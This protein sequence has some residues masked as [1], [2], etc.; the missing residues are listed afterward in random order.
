M[1]HVNIWTRT[2]PD[3]LDITELQSQKSLLSILG[4]LGASKDKDIGRKAESLGEGKTTIQELSASEEGEETPKVQFTGEVDESVYMS[5]IDTLETKNT[6][7][8]KDAKES[9]V[10]QQSHNLLATL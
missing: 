5:T 10:I 2:L 8:S 4:S 6:Q 9:Q 1:T 7:E 3:T